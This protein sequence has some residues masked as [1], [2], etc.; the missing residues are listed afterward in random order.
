MHDAVQV[1]ISKNHHYGIFFLKGFPANLPNPFC[2]R[3]N[4]KP[5]FNQTAYTNHIDK[6]PGCFNFLVRQA[7][8]AAPHGVSVDCPHRCQHEDG[9]AAWTSNKRHALLR[10]H[11]VN[12]ILGTDG[13]VPVFTMEQNPNFNFVGSEA[14]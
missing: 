5:F 4:Q 8:V 14:Q 11:V 10:H 1:F 9:N 12:D 3:L 7:Q 6:S 13:D 2:N